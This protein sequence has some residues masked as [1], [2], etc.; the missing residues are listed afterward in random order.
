MMNYRLATRCSHFGKKAGKAKTAFFSLFWEWV[1]PH[2]PTFR[3][4]VGTPTNREKPHFILH[5]FLYVP[6]SH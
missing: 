4:K 1:F 3:K 5:K 6:S 2:V